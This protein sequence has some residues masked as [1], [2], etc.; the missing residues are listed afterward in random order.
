MP[1]T[2]NLN[3]ELKKANKRAFINDLKKI[4]KDDKGFHLGSINTLFKKF[5]GI[6]L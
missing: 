2:K 1:G 4:F 3:I 6:I 5:S